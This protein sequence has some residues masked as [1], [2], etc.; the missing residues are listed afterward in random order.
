MEVWAILGEFWMKNEASRLFL[1]FLTD[2]LTVACWP[3]QSTVSPQQST[4]SH[5]QSNVATSALLHFLDHFNSRLSLP[6]SP[7]LTKISKI[8]FLN[9]N[10]NS[11]F[12]LQCKPN[13]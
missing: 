7:L 1:T 6:N 12:Q 13:I 10:L 2:I 5:Q 9:L 4:V 11:T 3:Q 8:D